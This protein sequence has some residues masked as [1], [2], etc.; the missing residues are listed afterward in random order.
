MS[1]RTA[2][3]TGASR[4][5]GIGGVVSIA[6]LRHASPDSPDPDRSR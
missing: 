2:L 1:T 6:R 3:M 4:R 5:A